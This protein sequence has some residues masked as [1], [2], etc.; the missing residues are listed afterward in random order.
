MTSVVNIYIIYEDHKTE[1]LPIVLRFEPFY[2]K[3]IDTVVDTSY[4]QDLQDEIAAQ[5]EHDRQYR[6]KHKI[7]L[8]EKY[9]QFT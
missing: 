9:K 5:I 8:I 1:I 2:E 6:N 4:L 7:I 3:D